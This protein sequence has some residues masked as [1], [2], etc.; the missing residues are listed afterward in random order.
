MSLAV[1]SGGVAVTSVKA[2]SLVTLTATVKAG[3]KAVKRGQVNFCDAM[4]AYCTDIHI[5][6]NAQLTSS[7]TATYNFR[8]GV[9]SRS[10]KAVGT[11]SYASLCGGGQS[12]ANLSLAKFPS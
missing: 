12:G 7:G 6:A 10:Y 9:G 2:G 1:T 3:T 4:A 5:L 11:T 8:P